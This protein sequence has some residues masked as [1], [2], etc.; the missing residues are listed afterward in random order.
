M[1]LVTFSQNLVPLHGIRVHRTSRAVQFLFP[2]SSGNETPIGGNTILTNFRLNCA[3]PE[4][5]C[6]FKHAQRGYKSV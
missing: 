5:N 3:R 4:F 1:K 2:I 6:S